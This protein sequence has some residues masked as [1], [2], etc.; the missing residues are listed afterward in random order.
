MK[1]MVLDEVSMRRRV[2]PIDIASAGIGAEEG[3]PASRHAVTIAAG[4]GIDLNFH[5]SRQLTAI[6]RETAISS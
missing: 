1:D 6:W 4:H 2:L 3:R 5:R